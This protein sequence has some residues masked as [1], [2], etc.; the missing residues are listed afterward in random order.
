MEPRCR[1]QRGSS[2]A[3]A[4]GHHA[5]KLSWPAMISC[6]CPAPACGGY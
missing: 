4:T 5:S 3:P 6:R 2:L 1:K